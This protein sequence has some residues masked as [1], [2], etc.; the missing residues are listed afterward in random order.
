M[1]H[2]IL[3]NDDALHNIDHRL[4]LL[5]R[6]VNWIPKQTIASELFR[7]GAARMVQ[8]GELALLIREPV[9]FCPGFFHHLEQVRTIFLPPAGQVITRSIITLS[10]W[11]IY[12]Q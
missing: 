6:F 12:C 5:G 4:M 11:V 1:A 7:T 8:L 10:C 9:D 3:A 2:A